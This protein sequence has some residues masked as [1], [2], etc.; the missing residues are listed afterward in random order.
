M[1]RKLNSAP[2]VAFGTLVK[3]RMYTP[4]VDCCKISPAPSSL[5][6]YRYKLLVFTFILGVFAK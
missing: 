1:L 6:S 2:N 4:V 3:L 5:G